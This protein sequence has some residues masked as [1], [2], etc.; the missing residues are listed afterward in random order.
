MKSSSHVLFALGTETS[1]L[2]TPHGI[3]EINGSPEACRFVAD[4]YTSTRDAATLR[5]LRDVPVTV[6]GEA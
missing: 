1:F 3:V 6:E 4:L 2:T 5:G